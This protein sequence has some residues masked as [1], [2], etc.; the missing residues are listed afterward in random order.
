MV[1]ISLL[2]VVFM[3]VKV[4]NYK[5]KLNDFMIYVLREVV[6]YESDTVLDV[7]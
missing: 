4:K 2:F 5:L 6:V 7:N 1:C 3:L